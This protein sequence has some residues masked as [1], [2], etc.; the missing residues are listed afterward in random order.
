VYP[1][2]HT[3]LLENDKHVWADLEDEQE[4]NGIWKGQ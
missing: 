1:V 3:L 4:K 2:T